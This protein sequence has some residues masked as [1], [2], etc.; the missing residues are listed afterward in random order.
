MRQKSHHVSLCNLILGQTRVQNPDEHDL[1]RNINMW[2]LP[3][4]EGTTELLLLKLEGT[5]YTTILRGIVNVSGPKSTSAC[6]LSKQS[7]VIL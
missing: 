7:G 4:G 6:G 1:S 5:Y 2:V 3:G